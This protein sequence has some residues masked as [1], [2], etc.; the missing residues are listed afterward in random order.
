M[1]LL[2]VTPEYPPHAAGGILKY[3]ELMTAAWSAAGAHV[4]VLMSSPFCSF[5]SYEHG[6]IKVYSTSLERINWHAAHLT[7]LAAAPSYRQ[8]IAAGLAARDWVQSTLNTFDVI[9]TTDFGL[10]FAPL[11]NVRDRPPLVV[12]LHGSIGQMSEHEPSAPAKELDV[13]LARLTEAAVLPSV[14]ALHACSHANAAEWQLRLGRDVV[15]VPVPLPLPSTTLAAPEAHFAGVVVGRG[16][17]FW[18]AWPIYV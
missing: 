5:D 17:R 9:E 13:A 12:K 7:H 15:F 11:V 10:L 6:G 1:R 4:S 2:V 8:W 3:Y 16:H 18:T 14:N